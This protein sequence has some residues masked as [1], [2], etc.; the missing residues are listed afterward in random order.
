MTELLLFLAGWVAGLATFVGINVMLS[1][2]FLPPS[3]IV[4][5]P[6]TTALAR[7]A[8]ELLA[9]IDPEAQP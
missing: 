8:R 6:R 3:E 7:A 5:S 4:D 2:R 1:Q 9:E